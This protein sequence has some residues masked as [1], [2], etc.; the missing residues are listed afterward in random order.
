M[1]EHWISE[2]SGLGLEK[3]IQISKL[4]A[5]KNHSFQKKI[6]NHVEIHPSLKKTQ[7]NM[8]TPSF[9]LQY[10]KTKYEQQQTNQQTTTTTKTQT[11]K[12]W[13]GKWEINL[14]SRSV[15]EHWKNRLSSIPYLDIE[16]CGIITTKV[17]FSIW[18]CYLQSNGTMH[19]SNTGDTTS[20]NN[21]GE[22][23]RSEIASLSQNL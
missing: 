16:A 5:L 7:P 22:K 2:H 13:R 14:S 8:E 12:N 19:L 3:N 18:F 11:P 23:V 6:R 1:V 17:K 9:P 10:K 4:Y 21:Q 20:I 15:T